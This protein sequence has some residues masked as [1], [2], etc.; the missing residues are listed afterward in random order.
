MGRT[1]IIS[2]ANNIVVLCCVMSL[3]TTIIYSLGT[4]RVYCIV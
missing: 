2:T 1:T 4:I 3:S